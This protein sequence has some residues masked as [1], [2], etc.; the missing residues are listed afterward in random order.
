M[1]VKLLKEDCIVLR[2]TFFYLF[3]FVCLFIFFFIPFTWKPL[4]SN[5]G[6]DI[7]EEI[8]V[9]EILEW[10]TKMEPEGFPPFNRKEEKGP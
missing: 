1:K 7:N 10:L 4:E 8:R 6:N 2:H 5:R 9:R 3:H